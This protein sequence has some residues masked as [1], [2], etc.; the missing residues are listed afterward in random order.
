MKNE[1]FP[2]IKSQFNY[3]LTMLIYHT[4]VI[5]V[6]LLPLKYSDADKLHFLGLASCVAIGI[7]ISQFIRLKK[8]N[9]FE[10]TK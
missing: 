7:T 2:F 3:L 5:A 10:K 4:M 8:K 1:Y 6:T 9:L